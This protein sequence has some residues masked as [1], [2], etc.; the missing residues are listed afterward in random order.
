VVGELP[1]ELARAHAVAVAIQDEVAAGLRPGAIP[2]E[3]WE[4]ARGRAER[5]GLGDRFMGP[6]GDQARFVAHGVGLELDELPILAPGFREPLV[7]GQVLAVEPKFVFPG[8]GA[9]GVENVYAVTERGGD[10]LCDLPDAVLRVRGE[11]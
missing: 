5:E 1:P 3:L 2:A 6:P 10:R 9:V 11:P 8:L 7:A 4:R